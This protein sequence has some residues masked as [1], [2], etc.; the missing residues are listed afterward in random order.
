MIIR[1]VY[2]CFLV[3]LFCNPCSSIL[4][5][6]TL[7]YD[8]MIALETINKKSML[9]YYLIDDPIYSNKGF[10]PISDTIIQYDIG[11]F[12][13]STLSIVDSNGI[14]DG[15]QYLF[16]YY[17]VEDS[18]KIEQKEIC[19]SYDKRTNHKKILRKINSKKIRERNYPILYAFNQSKIS[20]ES[21]K[22]CYIPM[23]AKIILVSKP[24]YNFERYVFDGKNLKLKEIKFYYISELEIEGHKIR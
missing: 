13:L 16:N 9:N 1:I 7:R 6:D 24:E 19:Y 5:Q 10:Y 20:R 14:V 11:F 18:T 2:K 4:S 15:R 22:V 12:C 3:L 23:K 21:L 17:N 8:G